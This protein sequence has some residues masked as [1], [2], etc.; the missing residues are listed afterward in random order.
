MAKNRLNLP[1]FEVKRLAFFSFKNPEKAKKPNFD[2]FSVE[3]Q[4]STKIDGKRQNQWISC[5][6]WFVFMVILNDG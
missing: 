2:S 3:A 5:L 6:F 1:K 4:I